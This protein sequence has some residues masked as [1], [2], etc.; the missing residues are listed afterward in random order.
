MT[1]L[2]GCGSAYAT[3]GT[4]I[5]IMAKDANMYVT[6]V[7]FTFGCLILIHILRKRS[8]LNPNHPN[9]K[10]RLLIQFRIETSGTLKDCYY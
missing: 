4:I 10:S 3:S 6:I 9:Y 1:G 7:V 5:T 8:I 2:N